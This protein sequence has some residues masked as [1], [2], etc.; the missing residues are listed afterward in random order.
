MED[1]GKTDMGSS[2]DESVGEPGW[3]G[4]HSCLS[5][6]ESHACAHGL[7]RTDLPEAVGERLWL[8]CAQVCCSWL[9]GGGCAAS[10]NCGRKPQLAEGEPL[11][12]AL[13]PT[14]C[15]RSL[16]MLG[17]LSILLALLQQSWF[18]L[19]HCS[20]FIVKTVDSGMLGVVIGGSSRGQQ[21]MHRGGTGTPLCM[22]AFC[23]LLPT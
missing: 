21:E 5:E 7:G 13:L 11:C 9:Q 16:S 10:P 22:T 15:P 8:A 3:G 20:R 12:A 14:W 6:R 1:E 18:R 2:L 4:M 19:W 17:M 23:M